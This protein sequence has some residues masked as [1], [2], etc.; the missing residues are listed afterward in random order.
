LMYS[1]LS[2]FIERRPA[3]AIA[4]D[5]LSILLDRVVQPY[6]VDALDL[7]LEK[8]NLTSNYPFLSN[9]LRRGFAL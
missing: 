1:D 2:A 5:N 3:P 7:L 9:N 8:H 6:N 4:I